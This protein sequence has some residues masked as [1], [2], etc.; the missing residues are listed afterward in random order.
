MPRSSKIS[1]LPSIR[2][3]LHSQTQSSDPLDYDQS[4]STPRAPESGPG[5]SE[6]TECTDSGVA[7][8]TSSSNPSDSVLSNNVPPNAQKEPSNLW[9]MALDQLSK[10]SPDEQACIRQLQKA[11][12][13][14]TVVD[15]QSIIGKHV[16]DD[17][18]SLLKRKL[19]ESDEKAFEITFRQKTYRIR[20]VLDKTISWLNS[21]KEVGDIAVNYD[22]VHA[23]LPWAAFR[24][25]LQ[26]MT[27]GMQQTAEMVIGLERSIQFSLRGSI[28]EQMYLD[29]TN[30]EP[31]LILQAALLDL[32]RALIVLMSDSVKHQETSSLRKAV[33]GTLQPQQFAS[34][35][36]KLDAKLAWVET[37]V[38]IC[39]RQKIIRQLD[40][41]DTRLQAL[42]ER[43]L[44]GLDTK[45][46][47][48]WTAIQDRERIEAMQWISHVPFESDYGNIKATRLEGT[49]D[50]LLIHP[51]YIQWRQSTCSRTLWLHGIPGAGK[52][53]LTSRVVEVL[54]NDPLITSGWESLA[55]FFCDRNRPDRQDPAAVLRSLVRQMSFQNRTQDIIACTHE[56]FM[57]KKTMGFASAELT[58]EDCQS[59]ISQLSRSRPKST[60]IIDGLDECNP[61]SRHVLLKALD[62]IRATSS[63]GIMKIF[64]ASRDDDDIK[65]QFESGAHLRIQVSNNQGDIEKYINDKM[66]SSRW[67]RERMS[68]STRINILDTF[69]RKSQGMFQ[70]AALHIVEL[71]ELKSDSLVLEYLNKLPVGLEETYRQVY[72]SIDR[73]KKHLTDRAFQWVMCSWKPL[74]PQELVTAVAQDSSKPFNSQVDIDINMLMDSCKNLLVV[75]D[76]EG[77]KFCRF[78]HL[79]VQEYLELHHFTNT[80]AASFVL[81]I[82]IKYL[83][84]ESNKSRAP[85]EWHKRMNL[86]HRQVEMVDG[87]VL[88]ATRDSI[89]RFLGHPTESSLA[90]RRWAQAV[91]GYNGKDDKFDILLRQR[92]KSGEE[93]GISWICCVAYC[94]Y[95]VLQDWLQT[96]VLKP[97]DMM[98]GKYS[99]LGFAS[100]CGQPLIWDLLVTSGVGIN[101]PTGTFSTPLLQLVAGGD[102]RLSKAE[103]LLEHGA[104]VNTKDPYF[105][106]ALQMAASYGSFGLVRLLINHG[107]DINMVAGNYS[108]ALQAA[109]AHSHREICEILLEK[110]ADV[111]IFGGSCYTPLMAA[112]NQ[113]DPVITKML[114]ERGADVNKGDTRNTKPLHEA[115]FWGNASMVKLLIDHGAEINVVSSR[116]GTPLYVSI[117]SVSNPSSEVISLLLGAG[118]HLGECNDAVVIAQLDSFERGELMWPKPT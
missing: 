101:L 73:R 18:H 94:I 26:T 77:G 111:N 45:L 53:R 81:D 76:R 106:T 57:R 10:G 115:I 104:D 114:L 82:H 2:K 34:T 79:S 21:F 109:A 68:E 4:A 19:S 54:M 62:S 52:T 78:S 63:P 22:P 72:E 20:D 102:S 60:I 70:W 89:K 86:W 99:A 80:E 38:N 116:H 108:T 98:Y 33:A 110:G 69:R 8:V 41:I 15:R 117:A 27:I 43:Q 90:Y 105:G 42:L 13:L 47:D 88:P 9:V 31:Q 97:E 93:H 16:V 91:L 24:F 87:K 39:H 30:T 118:A 1:P 11:E 32:Y 112:V 100:L 64:I 103:A 17:V 6:S 74:S 37:A 66:Q 44:D 71:L 7:N 25:L 50:W 83:E 56:L 65:Y 84:V 46:A 59:L 36:D 29:G 49:C 40:K 61:K 3:R 55:Y 48:V 75:E 51:R 28:Y 67:C 35:L 95:D 58:M 85:S 96:K 92:N 5:I 12:L 14:P 113:G 107:A 23:A